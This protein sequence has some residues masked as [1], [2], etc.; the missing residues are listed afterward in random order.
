[1]KKVIVSI[2]L[3]LL[4]IT[5]AFAF[6]GCVS[7]EMNVNISKDNIGIDISQDLYGLFIEDISYACD[8]GL[9]SNLIANTSF[10]YKASPLTNWVI[11]DLD[12]AVEDIYS[13]NDNNKSYLK[14]TASGDGALLN[15]GYVEYYKYLTSTYQKGLSDI[16]DMGFAKD[17]VYKFVCYIK[18]IDY[19]GSA[20]IQLYSNN[21]KVPV[22][23]DVPVKGSDWTKVET[24]IKS[25]ATED[26]GMQLELSG[27]GTLCFDSFELVSE[28]SYGYS[29]SNWKYVSLR[30]DLYNAIKE[31]N[32]SFVR[33]PGGCLAEGTSLEELYDWKE[34]IGPLCERKHYSNIWNDDEHGLTYDNTNSMGYHEYFQLCEDLNAKALPILNAGMI[35]Q[36][37]MYKDGEKYRYW[38]GKYR[39]GL[40]S[41]E[42]WTNY[43]NQYALVPGTAEFDAYVQDILD[44]I[45]YANGDTSTTW[46]AKRAQNGHVEPFN[47]QYIGIGNENWGDI[48]WRNFDA[49][50][51]V[52]KEKHPEIK[53]I[54]SA[55][56]WFDGKEKAEDW[57][58]IDEKYLDTMVDEHYYTEHNQMFKNNDFYDS[59]SRD[60]E[61]FVGEYA[62]TTEFFGKYLTKNNIW[63]AIEEAG[64]MCGF[65]RNSDVVKMASYAPTFA[66]I[67]AQT[68]KINLIWFDSQNIVLTPNY[69]TQMLY[70]NNLGKQVINTEAYNDGCYSV[71]TVDQDKQIVYFKIVNSNAEKIK[72]NLDVQGFG[73]INAANMQYMS[74]ESKAACNEL[75]STTV[76]P[77]QV[78]CSVNQNVVSTEVDGYSINI[79]RVAY[80][81]ND[82]SN[83]YSLPNLPSN[84]EQNVTKYTKPYLTQEGFIAICIIGGLFVLGS[85]ACVVV[86]ILRKKGIIKFSK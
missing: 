69:F 47:L 44:L 66:K 41:E 45:E 17:S 24:E 34:T 38:E 21:N 67:N 33:F 15:K 46:G 84:M 13:M 22:A 77:Y 12:Y 6:M 60:R 43:I 32:P 50:Y 25:N 83:F 79:I 72:I 78:D 71:T 64:Y 61:V 85:I 9:V 80:G 35:C 18:N 55:A 76:I 75:G 36:F 40:M 59:Y 56:A 23:I 31:L 20:S 28:D 54:S 63:A 42:D 7:K 29:D 48:Y 57:A 16:P 74:N 2:L 30:S 1:M 65:E 81:D 27:N 14:V 26:G 11:S 82:G 73:N 10:D 37:K 52:L 5:S 86:V 68:W 4:I 8:G 70:S 62:T 49:I 19:E 58:V 51:K 39:K 53:I 3:L